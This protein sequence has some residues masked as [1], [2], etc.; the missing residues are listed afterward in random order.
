MSGLT[1]VPGTHYTYY[2]TNFVHSD[3]PRER[4][5][6]IFGSRRCVAAKVPFKT[7]LIFC[8]HARLK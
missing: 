1:P 3:S 8:V 5:V 4:D 2:E 7:C 6:H